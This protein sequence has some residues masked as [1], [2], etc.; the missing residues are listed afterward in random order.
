M[1][2]FNHRC[3]HVLMEL[4][5]EAHDALVR[6]SNMRIMVPLFRDALRS[7]SQGFCYIIFSILSY[8]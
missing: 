8:C 7:S 4:Q 2:G 5:Y 3:W 1:T 6:V